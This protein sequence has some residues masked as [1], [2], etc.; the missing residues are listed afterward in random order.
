MK[1]YNVYY[2]DGAYYGTMTFKNKPQIEIERLIQAE[3]DRNNKNLNNQYHI[4][5]ANFKEL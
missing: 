2:N 5:R 3:I 4:T 1:K